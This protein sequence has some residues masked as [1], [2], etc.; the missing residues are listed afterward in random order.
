MTGMDRATIHNEHEDIHVWEWNVSYMPA[1]D[2]EKTMPLE[3]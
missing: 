3:L 1:V 2:R